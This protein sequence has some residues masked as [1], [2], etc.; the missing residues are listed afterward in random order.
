MLNEN[1]NLTNHMEYLVMDGSTNNAQS[2]LL[3]PYPV[4]RKNQ[5]CLDLSDAGQKQITYAQSHFSS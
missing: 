1:Q 3:W 4:M 5:S 2:R